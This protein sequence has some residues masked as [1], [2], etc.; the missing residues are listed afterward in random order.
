MTAKSLGYFHTRTQT[1]EGLTH[2]DRGLLLAVMQRERR[3]LC[4]EKTMGSD[5]QLWR[6]REAGGGHIPGQLPET[7]EDHKVSKENSRMGNHNCIHLAS[8]PGH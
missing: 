4:K 8:L 7:T 5:S 3:L 1:L 6:F 2:L